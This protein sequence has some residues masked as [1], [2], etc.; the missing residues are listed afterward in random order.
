MRIHWPPSAKKKNEIV[1]VGL[2]VPGVV[3]T[4]GVLL[5]V[6]EG[7][8]AAREKWCMQTHK[9]SLQ[10][11]QILFVCSGACLEPTSLIIITAPHPPILPDLCDGHPP[12]WQEK[13][14]HLHHV[15]CFDG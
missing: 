10:S 11:A 7:K 4:M 2:L 14:S 3:L 8:T 12:W 15:G 9:V 5:D 6:P 13:A 1:L